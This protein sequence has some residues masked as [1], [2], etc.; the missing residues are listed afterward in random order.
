MDVAIR[1]MWGLDGQWIS[2]LTLGSSRSQEGKEGREAF[3]L[4]GMRV[5]DFVEFG[6]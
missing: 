3:H 5:P 4:M 1:L 6:V 2:E